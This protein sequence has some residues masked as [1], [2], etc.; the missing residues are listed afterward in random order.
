MDQ[1]NE[2]Q[3]QKDLQRFEKFRR[4]EYQDLRERRATQI[5]KHLWHKQRLDDKFAK[6]FKDALLVAEEIYLIDVIAKEPVVT[7]LNPKNV[8]TI[9]SG[10]S[11]YIEDA[12]VICVVGYHSPG[13]IIDEYHEELSPSEIDMIESRYITDRGGKLGIDIGYKP[14]LQMKLDEDILRVIGDNNLGYSAPYDE[15]GNIRVIKIYWRSMRKM[16]KVKYYDEFG[17]PQEELFDENYKIDTTKGEEAE[18]IW[19]N[20]W[21]EGHKIGGGLGT[22]DNALYKKIRIK[23]IQYR[24]MENPSKCHPGIVGTLYNTNDNEAVSL[25]D[26][27]K[28]YQYLYNILAYNTELMISKNKGKIMRLGLH[29]IP[30]NWQIDQW[31]SFAESM[32]IAVYDAFKE[33]NKGTALGKIAGGMNPQQPVIDM[34]MGNSIQMYMNMMNYIKQEMGEIAGV[35]QARQAQISTREAVSNVEREISQS[36]H[37]TEYWFAEHDLVK[38]RV[39]EC[40][41]EAAK[42]AWKNE[43]NKKVQFVL[44]DGSTDIFEVDGEQFNEIDY[45]IAI[46]DGAGS[47]ELRNALKSLA[48]AALQNQML[49]FSQIMDIYSTDSLAS[50]RRKIQTFEEDKNNQIAKANEQKQV[51]Q[52]QQLQAQAEEAERARNFEREKWDREDAR[53]TENNNTK[54]TIKNM[55]LQNS[56][57]DGDGDPDNTEQITLNKLRQDW[58]MFEKEFKL[59]ETQLQETIR[60]NKAQETLKEKDL[61]IKKSK[62][63]SPKK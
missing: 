22:S 29:E 40:L 8:F 59:K 2:E 43:K 11:P 15:Y 24:S 49:N 30:E 21:W 19:I 26:R 53:N 58:A 60:K 48:Q 36:S 56:D 16:L 25:M 39:L 12:D 9:R 17:D 27:M 57:T 18:E 54:I 51:L 61:A 34:E 4:Y 10:E 28:P 47:V 42:Y 44:D 52:D 41:L 32:N 20:E 63:A 1:Q 45:D 33:G 6:G 46:T 35:S 5:L 7:R 37:I 31:L 23:P 50:I 55:E 62:P 14:D 13:M 38:R 3:I